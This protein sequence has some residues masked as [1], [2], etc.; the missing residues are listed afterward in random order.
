MHARGQGGTTGIKD[1]QAVFRV[2]HHGLDSNKIILIVGTGRRSGRIV[3]GTAWRCVEVKAGI[4]CLCVVI[5]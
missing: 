4:R 3:D 5:M 2:D 1:P